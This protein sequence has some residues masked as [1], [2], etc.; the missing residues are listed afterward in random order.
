MTGALNDE[1]RRRGND[2][3][4]V[5]FDRHHSDP[6]RRLFLIVLMHDHASDWPAREK[7]RPSLTPKSEYGV[8][9]SRNPGRDALTRSIRPL[10]AS[11][12]WS[13]MLVMRFQGLSR[14]YP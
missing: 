4:S 6:G 2:C 12:R 13:D 3:R 5:W 7:V 1:E 9:I 11:G 14:F 8:E 10:R